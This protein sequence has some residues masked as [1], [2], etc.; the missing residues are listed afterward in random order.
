ASEAAAKLL[1]DRG[2][3][4]DAGMLAPRILN[5]DHSGPCPME[6]ACEGLDD[7]AA[8]VEAARQTLKALRNV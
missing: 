2:I 4:S 3:P 1:A 6:R 8:I 7:P 5:R